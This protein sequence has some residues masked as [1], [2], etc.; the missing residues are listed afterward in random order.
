M[1][2][3][4][5]FF[6]FLIVFVL[7]AYYFYYSIYKKETVHEPQ[8]NFEVKQGETATELAT[9]LEKEKIISDAWLF[10]KYLAWNN[11]DKKI[12]FG[13][14]T[15]NS[16]LTIA[17]IASSLNQPDF[18]E[19]EITILPGWDI[20]D[21]ATYFES[22]AMFQAEETTELIGLPAVD[23]RTAKDVSKPD[24]DFAKYKVLRDKPEYVSYEGY[25]APET[26]RVFADSDLK[27]ILEKFIAYRDS[28]FT[29][30]MYLEIEKQGKTV[31]QILTLASILEKEVKTL[32]DKK[33]VADLFWRRL[34]E[35][36]ALQADSTVH[37][38]VFKTGTVF[39]TSED[40]QT[41]SLWNTYKYP[42]LPLSPIC[43]PSLDSIMAAIYPT[44]NNYNFFLTDS[45][46]QVHYAVTNEQHNYN[47]YKYL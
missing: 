10:K 33:I 11:L 34:E 45:N 5:I 40:R 32:A 24:V 2:L 46:G 41:D 26:I 13:N 25:L 1:R 12:K 39:T 23:Y 14:Y 27:E 42:G 17:N 30:E 6:L 31:Y 35:N 47:R 43:N 9:R 28:Q 36:W 20:R 37:Y 22:L 29:P 7:F 16:P 18:N 8:I 38:A 15:V 21:V 3:N 4:K 19:K 44:K